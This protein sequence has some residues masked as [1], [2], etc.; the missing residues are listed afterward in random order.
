MNRISSSNSSPPIQR[1]AISVIDSTMIEKMS[2]WITN[3]FFKNLMY[4]LAI[5]TIYESC[6]LLLL[7]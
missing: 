2:S 6:I 7:S 4:I 3:I 1:S 5:E